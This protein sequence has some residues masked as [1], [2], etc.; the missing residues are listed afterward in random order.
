MSPSKV[1]E[2]KWDEFYNIVNGEKRGGKDK[3]QGISQ[4][5]FASSLPCIMS[6][7]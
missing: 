4:S 6:L 7:D 5:S 3:H 1:S 2:I